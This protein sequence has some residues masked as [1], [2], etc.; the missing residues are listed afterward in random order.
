MKKTRTKKRQKL[1]A[2]YIW[3]AH[4]PG[5]ASYTK[6]L[7]T[8]RPHGQGGLIPLDIGGLGGWKKVA[9]YAEWR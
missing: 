1:G 4:D 3:F 5:E 2:G 8:Q 9:L 6:V 7:L